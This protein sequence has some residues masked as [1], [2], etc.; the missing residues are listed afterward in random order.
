MNLLAFLKINRLTWPWILFAGSCLFCGCKN[1][2]ETL[3]QQN[4]AP[5]NFIVT[6]SEIFG[7]MASLDWR[8][9]IDPDGDKI[10]YSI[11][12]KGEEIQSD[13]QD[14][15]FLFQ[16]LDP[17]N[18]YDG[19]VIARDGKG[20]FTESVFAFNT[21][22]LVIEWQRSLGGTNHESPRSIIQTMD[23]SYVI[24]GY[25]FSNDGDISGNHGLSDSWIVKLNERGNFIWE[26]NLGGAGR[27]AAYCILETE[28]GGFVM[29][30]EASHASGDVDSN[31]GNRD[32]WIVKLDASGTL[33]W[34]TN[35]GGSN[36]DVASSITLAGDEGYVIGGTS[37]SSNGD[38]K[39]NHGGSDFWIV[40]LD[41]G[42]SLVWESNFG[43]SDDD[44]CVSIRQTLDGGYIAA[45]TS[46]SSDGD[47]DSNHGR[48]DFW[49]IKLDSFG[50]LVWEANYGGS[51]SDTATEIYQLSNGEYIVAGY[52]Y[53]SDL[54]VGE[55][56]GG[57]DYWVIKLDVIGNLMWQTS[58]GGEDNDLVRSMYSSDQGYIVA[59]FAGSGTGD[60]SGNNGL[61]DCWIQKLD[62][63]GEQVWEE[64]FGG[65]ETDIAYT[66]QRTMDKGFV[67]AGS[68]MSSDGDVV[69]NKGLSDFWVVK[70][71]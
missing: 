63:N 66:I 56:K 20:G 8:A 29:A 23:G 6:V 61:A 67:F 25:S 15:G 13:L 38:V 40:K 54:D 19:K 30:G 46:S 27:E 9:A 31:N 4:Q 3:S 53:S 18:S 65:S 43:G 21:T 2:E 14:T 59:G 11:W 49:I 52:S 58:M 28:D 62:G 37:R 47:V 22:A 32:Y 12:L 57:A 35:L 17:E 42:G 33:V 51:D 55:N 50:K 69:G 70:L 44:V 64:N 36:V 68:S 7:T 45:G 10:T 41:L 39:N 1:D 34:E 5:G 26:T 16:G 60:V 24:A 71:K 48:S